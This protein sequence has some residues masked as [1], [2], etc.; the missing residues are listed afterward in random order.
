MRKNGGISIFSSLRSIPHSKVHFFST[1]ES[2]MNQTKDQ[3][4]ALNVR[5]KSS[6]SSAH[7][8]ATNYT[9]VGGPRHCV[10]GF[11][12]YRAGLTRRDRQNGEGWTGGTQR[13]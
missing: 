8:R 1:K 9:N 7:P 10:R 12:L 13:D 5:L 4:L 11:R 2:S 3:V 6:D